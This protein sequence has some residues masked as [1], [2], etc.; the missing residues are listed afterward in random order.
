[1]SRTLRNHPANPTVDDET[2]AV[3]SAI[4][5]LVAT[6]S[7]PT[8][9]AKTVTKH[10]RA[11]AVAAIS[12]IDEHRAVPT[13]SNL[14]NWTKS[15]EMPPKE[16]KAQMPLDQLLIAADIIARWTTDTSPAV[17]LAVDLF[18]LFQAGR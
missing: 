12:A 7:S 5:R 10:S 15:V 18:Q 8:P 14:S 3:A 4:Y 9:R 1:M 2:E 13:N 16:A 17:E 6:S 11:I